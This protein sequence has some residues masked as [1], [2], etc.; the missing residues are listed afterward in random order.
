MFKLAAAASALVMSTMAHAD[1]VAH[2]SSFGAGTIIEDTDTGLSY[3]RLDLTFGMSYT[4]VLSQLGEG[5]SFAGFHIASSSEMLSLLSNVAPYFTEDPQAAFR[6]YTLQH[7]QDPATVFR[8]ISFT[9]LFGVNPQVVNGQ[10]GASFVAQYGDPF[11]SPDY[12]AN[13]ACGVESAGVFWHLGSDTSAGGYTD[14]I[15]GT[16]RDVVPGVG[17]LLVMTPVPEPQTYALMLAG[18]GVMGFMA[19]R[20]SSVSTRP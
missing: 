3:A 16:I 7:E 19:R 6:F 14:G 5:G 4:D 12:C 13:F 2:D 15:Y 18:L 11:H 20:R 8:A 1:L 10:F 17:T 9:T